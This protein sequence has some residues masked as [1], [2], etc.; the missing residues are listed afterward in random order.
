[1]AYVNY[2]MDVVAFHRFESFLAQP[3]DTG[4]TRTTP[5]RLTSGKIEFQQV[6]FAFDEVRVLSD[7][8]LTLAGGQTTALVGTSGSGK[9]TL[10]RLLLHLFKPDNGRIFIDNQDLAKVD[11]HTLYQQVAYI[12]QEPPVFD[13]TIRENLL[14]DAPIADEAIRAVLQQV[15]LLEV[16]DRLPDGL[17]TVV[18]ERGIKLSGGERQRLAF[19]RVLLHDPQIIILDEPTAA[20]DSVTERFVSDNMRRFL[21]GKTVVVIAHR[22]QT[23][24]AADGIL[25]VANGRIVQQG[26]FTSLINQPGLF[27]QLWQEQT[28]LDDNEKE[29]VI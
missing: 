12:P 21:Q 25:V 29:Q 17:Q 6:D 15:D 5:L 27:Q 28:N 16:L 1:M 24:Q 18:G 9:S 11:L 2:K 10:V 23:V 14:F 3:E 8:T 19:A 22:L 13:G 7:L 26:S 20:L 4:L